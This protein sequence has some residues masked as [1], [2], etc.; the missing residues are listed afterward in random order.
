MDVHPPSSAPWLWELWMFTRPCRW[1]YSIGQ[2]SSD[3]SLVH[4]RMEDPWTHGF[5]SQNRSLCVLGF[6]HLKFDKIKIWSSWLGY[7]I[8]PVH[9]SVSISF[10]QFPSVQ[11]LPEA[12]LQY[13]HACS[14]RRTTSSA[15]PSSP[16]LEWLPWSCDIGPPG[17]STWAPAFVCLG[18]AW[19]ARPT[20]WYVEWSGQGRWWN[21]T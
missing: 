19:R 10:H 12:G 4:A 5:P 3:A 18:G 9:P 8:S 7:G 14:R 2:L 6:W 16:L 13:R 11:D 15:C 1:S 17:S 20:G 21:K